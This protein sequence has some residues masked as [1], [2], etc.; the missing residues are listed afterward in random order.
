MLFNALMC[1]I[2]NTQALSALVMIASVIKHIH[3]PYQSYNS[4]LSKKYMIL[5]GSEM[6]DTEHSYVFH[7]NIKYCS[8]RNLR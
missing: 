6:F 5:K 7:L 3:V 2:Y 4:F 8:Y 1:Y